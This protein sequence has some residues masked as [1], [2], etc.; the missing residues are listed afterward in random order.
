M[1]KRRWLRR[2]AKLALGGAV[3]L[4]VLWAAI[5]RIPWLG[6]ALADGVRALVG[7][8]P[9]AWAE[10][11]AYSLQDRVNMWRYKDAKPV[12]FWGAPPSIASAISDVEAARAAEVE[13]NR[14]RPKPFN[15]PFPAVATPADGVWLPIVDPKAPQASAVMYKSL[16]HPDRRRSFAALALVA[17]DLRA[18]KLQ[19]VAGT[20]EPQSPRVH[21]KDR[22]GRVPDSDVPH[23]FA[24]FNGGFKATHGHYGMMLNGV[25]FLP[26]RDF[27]CTFVR[28]RDGGFRIGTWSTLKGE[29]ARMQYFRQTPPC[30]LE[31]GELPPLLSH[32]EYAKTW[33]ATVSG[34]TVI[35]RSAIGL[36]KQ[37]NT[38]FYGLG[39][40]MTAQALARGMRA[41]GAEQAAQLD[42]NFSYPRFLFYEHP[43]AG[44]PPLAKQS[45]IPN[46]DFTSDQYVTRPSIRD[47]FYLAREH[48][49]ASVEAAGRSRFAAAQAP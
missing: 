6:P 7:P 12:S 13:K 14:F 30:L 39:E 9:V 20:K 26:P 18:F 2:L 29:R 40:A 10:D 38:L 25:E 24:A 47:F 41:A 23:L 21:P 44:G 35:R 16:V 4:V 27:A 22:P 43:G 48:R 28:Y 1:R 5:H 42:V 32:H 31:A 8:K 17:I 19:L 3:A 45:I 46:I 49:H 37:R 36:N 11:I 15:A 33:G 34:D